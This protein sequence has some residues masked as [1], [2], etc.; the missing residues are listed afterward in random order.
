[1]MSTMEAAVAT[2]TG[3]VVVLIVWVY[4]SSLV[5]LLGAEF[6]HQYAHGEGSKSGRT[7]ERRAPLGA[8]AGE[9]QPSRRA[10]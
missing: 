2:S 5:F 8:G 10:P 9:A 4:H 7:S 1:M 3:T 6:T